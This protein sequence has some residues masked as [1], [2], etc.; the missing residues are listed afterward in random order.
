MMFLVNSEHEGLTILP[1]HRCWTACRWRA[2]QAA[3]GG[4]PGALPR[5]KYTFRDGDEAAVRRRWL[6]DLRRRDPGRAQARR[7]LHQ[8]QRLLP[9]DP[10]R[11]GGLRGAGEPGL[12]LDLEAARRE[13]PQHPGARADPRASPRTSSRRG[14]TSATPRTSTTPWQR[15]RAGEFQ[16]ALASTPRRCATSSPSPTMTSGCRAS[17]PTSTRSRSRGWCSTR[18]IR[19]STPEASGDGGA[20]LG[21]RRRRSILSGI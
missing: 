7:L 4:H 6:R 15:T 9:A 21:N 13:H 12:L 16:V 14:R 5:Q 10:P 20:S 1:T 3:R 8:H 2:C 11:R 18:W 17:R 19:D